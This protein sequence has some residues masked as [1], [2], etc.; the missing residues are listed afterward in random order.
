MLTF[1]VY[2]ERLPHL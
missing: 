1:P 2:L